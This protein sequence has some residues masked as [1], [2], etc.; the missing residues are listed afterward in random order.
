MTNYG[1]IYVLYWEQINKDI[2]V[3]L[4]KHEW[5]TITGQTAKLADYKGQVIMVVNT[6]SKCGLTPQYEQLQAIYDEYK[7][8]G[9]VILGFPCNQFL[10][11]EPGANESIQSFCQINYGVTFP[12]SEKIKVNGSDTHP[13][14]A[15]LKEA[16]PGSMGN[17]IK[18]NFNKFLISRDGETVKR[19]SPKTEPDSIRADIEAWLATE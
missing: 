19:F 18:W 10:G 1:I 13:L 4:F 11:Q 3:D 8:K 5:T 17:S 9:L 12:L 14:F 15:D 7:D 2:T 16:A 6:A